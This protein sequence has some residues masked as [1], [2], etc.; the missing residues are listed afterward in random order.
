MALGGM[1]SSLLCSATGRGT[2][3]D[4]VRPEFPNLQEKVHD[5]D[6]V[7]LDSAATSHKPVAV[8]EAIDKFYRETNSNVHRGA[9]QLSVKATDMYEDA[10][11]KVMKSPLPSYHGNALCHC[12]RCQATP[13]MPLW[14]SGDLQRLVG[15]AFVLQVAKFVNADRD[16]IIFTRGATEALNL[17]AYS[18]GM[19]N[20][21][22]PRR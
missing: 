11:A 19:T 12:H 5:K 9:H 16:E 15:G 14:A 3:A 17:V 7:Y 6:L 18:W 20:L 4:Q 2:L 1:A 10:R 13:V 21:G 22:M 8:L